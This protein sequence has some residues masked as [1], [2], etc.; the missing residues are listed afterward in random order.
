MANNQ[1]YSGEADVMESSAKT[2][3]NDV[4]KQTS[5]EEQKP[6][7]RVVPDRVEAFIGKQKGIPFPIDTVYDIERAKA[8]IKAFNWQHNHAPTPEMLVDQHFGS[9]LHRFIIKQRESNEKVVNLYSIA[10]PKGDHRPFETVLDSEIRKPT[11]DALLIPLSTFAFL[12]VMQ[13]QLLK[14]VASRSSTVL[15]SHDAL[16]LNS[17]LPRKSNLFYERSA[18][19]IKPKLHAMM[20]PT[21]YVPKFVKAK[22]SVIVVAA[23]F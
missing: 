13:K 19:G 1:D 4:A 18:F 8:L 2:A 21:I 6:K 5:S 22:D 20:P 12:D 10:T 15:C 7:V 16:N 9:S 14:H 17:E 23:P 11:R 3:T